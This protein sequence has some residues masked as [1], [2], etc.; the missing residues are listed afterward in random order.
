V[1]PPQIILSL[2]NFWEFAGGDAEVF[3]DEVRPTFLHGL[4]HY[5]GLDEDGWTEQGLE[6]PVNK[7]DFESFARSKKK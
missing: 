3:C 6:S 2:K 1:P 7:G 5:F 4:G